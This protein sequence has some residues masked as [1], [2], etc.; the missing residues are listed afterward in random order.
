MISAT[1]AFPDAFFP[2][3]IR[4]APLSKPVKW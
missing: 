2:A 4:C 1:E 3:M